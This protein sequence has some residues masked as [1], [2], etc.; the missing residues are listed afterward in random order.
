MNRAKDNPFAN[1][2]TLMLITIA[3]DSIV[4]LFIEKKSATINNQILIVDKAI[5][6]EQMVV[7]EV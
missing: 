5:L 7:S 6:I 3:L 4:E 2:S 1:L